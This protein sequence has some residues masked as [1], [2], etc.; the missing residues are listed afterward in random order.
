MRRPEIGLSH[1]LRNLFLGLRCLKCTNILFQ[2]CNSETFPIHRKKRECNFCNFRRSSK[3][4]I[5]CIVLV[6]IEAQERD[7]DWMKPRLSNLSPKTLS[8]LLLAQCVE[9]V[10]PSCTL[11]RK[12]QHHMPSC[13][14]LDPLNN[15]LEI[16][17]WRQSTYLDTNLFLIWALCCKVLQ[18]F[19]RTEC[20]LINFSSNPKNMNDPF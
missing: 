5:L 18:K 13:H 8:S 1:L 14:W 3:Y 19:G 12:G 15:H 20:M 4:I 16:K 9:L 11:L 10:W 7:C 6:L 2:P 17:F